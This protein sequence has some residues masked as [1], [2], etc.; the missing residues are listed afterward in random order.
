MQSK[1][2]VREVRQVDHDLDQEG[3]PE[4]MSFFSD[5]VTCYQ[6]ERKL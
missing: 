6:R 2:C 3:S 5:C 1:D 4:V